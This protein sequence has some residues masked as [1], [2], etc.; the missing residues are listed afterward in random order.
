MIMVRGSFG[1]L[2]TQASSGLPTTHRIFITH[3]QGNVFSKKAKEAHANL[4][5]EPPFQKNSG[6]TRF[7][8]TTR[9]N[10]KKL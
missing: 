6:E 2:K 7:F 1:F 9:A 3:P 4:S 8:N 10:K 5:A